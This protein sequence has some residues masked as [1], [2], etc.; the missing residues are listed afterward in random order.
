M[1]AENGD[2]LARSRTL[3]ITEGDFPPL[4]ADETERESGLPGAPTL[5]V[6]SMD[7]VLGPRP[8]A[9]LLAAAAPASG[10]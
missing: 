7:N 1:S 3:S 5:A 6:P 8:R 2:E 9:S 10:C 4:T